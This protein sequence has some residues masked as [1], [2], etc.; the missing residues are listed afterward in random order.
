VGGG[1]AAASAAEPYGELTHFGSAGTG[2]GQFQIPSEQGET[3]AFGADPTDNTLYVGDEPTAGE[4]RVQKLSATGQFLASVSFKPAHPIALEGIAVDPVKERVYVLAVALRGNGA[5]DPGTR[6][7][8]TLYAFKTKQSGEVLESA[9]SGTST[10]A[11]AGVLANPATMETESETQGHALLEPTRITVD[12][13][14]GG[15]GQR[16]GR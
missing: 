12:P 15:V 13:S 16:A 4:Y 10:E 5:V 11:K 8:G 6:A 1:A 7:A 3:H 9:V 14:R 2:K